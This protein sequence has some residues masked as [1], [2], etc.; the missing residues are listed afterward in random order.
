MSWQYYIKYKHADMNPDYTGS[1]SLWA[2][3]ESQA[4]QL[5][6]GRKTKVGQ[7]TT[8]KR[9]AMLQVISIEEVKNEH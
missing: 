6:T 5:L 7:W 2:S 4:L 3:S 1:K 8:N 9:G